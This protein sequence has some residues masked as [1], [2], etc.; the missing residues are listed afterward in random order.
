[1][2]GSPLNHS[3]IL[4]TLPVPVDAR[5]KVLFF[6]SVALRWAAATQKKKIPPTLTLQDSLF[7]VHTLFIY[8]FRT[9][10]TIKSN[11]FLNN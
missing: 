8:A 3:A 5:S 11:L 9:I 2:T 6:F 10:L 7:C 4:P 1:M